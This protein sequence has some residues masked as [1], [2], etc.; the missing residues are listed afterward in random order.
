MR[1][2]E[3]NHQTWQRSFQQFSMR[4]HYIIMTIVITHNHVPWECVRWLD[5]RVDVICLIFKSMRRKSANKHVSSMSVLIDFAV[6]PSKWHFRVVVTYFQ[7]RHIVEVLR[8]H[9]ISRHI[10]ICSFGADADFVLPRAFVDWRS[11]HVRDRHR[12]W[13]V[14][15]CLVGIQKPDEITFVIWTSET[16][17]DERESVDE[18]PF[19]VELRWDARTLWR[20][21]EFWRGIK[22]RWQASLP[23]RQLRLLYKEEMDL[24]KG[25]ANKSMVIFYQISVGII[26]IIIIPY[27]YG[28]AWYSE[29]IGTKLSKMFKLEASWID[30]AISKRILA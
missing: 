1:N 2:C 22:K 14:R 19:D 10:V 8:P 21:Y 26:T 6:V 17:S 9:V 20:K 24:A 16:E 23:V 28:I 7:P 11:D 15:H 13:M 25:I 3:R 30:I 18:A 29:Y 5:K 4:Y 12:F 27:T